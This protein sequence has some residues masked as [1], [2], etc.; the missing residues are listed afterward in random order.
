MKKNSLMLIS[1]LFCA[2][3]QNGCATIMTGTFQGTEIDSEP[4]GAAVFVNGDL[5]GTTPCEVDLDQDTD[6]YIVLKKEGYADTRVTLKKGV[7]GWLVLNVFTG[8]VPGLIVDA[9]AGAGKS[10]NEDDICVPLLLKGE[11]QMR[12]YDGDVVLMNVSEGNE[13]SKNE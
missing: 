4:S 10:F 3:L 8:L 7:N 5:A 13:S 11:K 6:P 12:F 9:W 2:L 1:L